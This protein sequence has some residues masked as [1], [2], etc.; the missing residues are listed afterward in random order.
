MAD[1]DDF[2]KDLLRLGNALKGTETKKFLKGQGKKL[3]KETQNT[4]KRL[5]KERTGNYI[6]GIKSGKIYDFKGA[7]STRV[8]SGARHAGLIEY[9]HKIVTKSG[10]IKGYKTGYHV[11]EKAKNN[12]EDEFIGAVERH[13]N[14]I[15]K[16]NGF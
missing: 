16:Q 8:Y 6:K 15:C 7:Y 3:Q 9:G 14:N 1:F 11:F 12:F 10:K 13:L 4:A 5:I 2:E